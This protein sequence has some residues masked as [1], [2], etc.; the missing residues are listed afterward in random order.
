MYVFFFSTHPGGRGSSVRAKASDQ[1]DDKHGPRVSS[2]SESDTSGRDRVFTK[3]HYMKVNILM[4]YDIYII[5]IILR[6]IPIV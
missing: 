1:G 5:Y 6:S 2:I 3:H 4:P